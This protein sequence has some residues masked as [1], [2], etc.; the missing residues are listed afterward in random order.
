MAIFAVGAI[1]GGIDYLIGNKWGFGEKFEEAINIMPATVFNMVGILCLA[2]AM[3]VV[4][5]ICIAPLYKMIGIDPSMLGGVLAL[6]M[7]GFPLAMELSENQLIGEYSGILVGSLLGCTLVFAIPFGMG[8]LEE[9]AKKDYIIGIIIGL[10]AMPV[11]LLAG[12]ITLGIGGYTLLYQ[13][14]P[15][16]SVC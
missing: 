5:K 6:D 7:G 12:G 10:I 8:V 3:A 9:G 11:G 15:V 1:I 2:P 16:F 14:M 13:S 4:L